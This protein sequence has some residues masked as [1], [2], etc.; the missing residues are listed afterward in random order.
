[1]TDDIQT[2][3]I[4]GGW[5]YGAPDYTVDM[6]VD[7][8]KY[9]T[10]MFV[11][12]DDNWK[13]VKLPRKN[14]K[15]FEIVNYLHTLHPNCYHSWNGYVIDNCITLTFTKISIDSDI[16]RTSNSGKQCIKV[17]FNRNCTPDVCGILTCEHAEGVETM[18]VIKHKKRMV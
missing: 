8:P 13:K 4:H 18:S 12:G 2:Y 15:R 11:K 7:T 9:P 3:M 1:M 10:P 6:W 16:K 14:M 5:S 17:S